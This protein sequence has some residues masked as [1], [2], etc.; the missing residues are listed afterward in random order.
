MTSETSLPSLLSMATEITAK[1]DL[2]AGT[3]SAT[4][5]NLPVGTNGQVL[6]ADSTV[7]P[8]GLKW[9]TPAGSTPTFVG[10]RLFNSAAQNIPNATTTAITFNSE[11][12]DTD[13]FHSTATNTSR[14]TI[15]AGKGGYYNFS[16]ATRWAGGST[17]GLR[18]QYLYKNGV[19][20]WAGT[21]QAPSNTS[22]NETLIYS[23]IVS[24]VA[25]DYFELFVY[26]TV[27][28]NYDVNGGSVVTTFQAQYLG[29]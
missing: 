17:T 24:A 15:P 19:E 3:G 13:A 6:T 5:D 9:A 2:I 1:G 16:G 21:F 29:A 27:G 25:T 7:S 11:S 4:F 28:A 22:I 10:C 23:Q 14:I 8:T 12:F 18:A 20:I 26:H